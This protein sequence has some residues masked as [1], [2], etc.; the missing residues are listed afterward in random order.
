MINGIRQAIFDL[1]SYV[2]GKPIAELLREIPGLKPNRIVKLASNESPVGPS[3]KAVRAA[4]K[5]IR[6]AHL[7]PEPTAY[8]LRQAIARKHAIAADG[9]IVT[10]GADEA[11]R[12]VAETLLEPQDTVVISRYAFPRFCQHAQLMGSGIIEVPMK[13]FCHDLK[14]MGRAAA[15]RKAKAVFIANPNNPTGTFNSDAEMREL[16]KSFSA[17]R[18]WIILDEAYYEFARDA[19]P[20]DYPDSLPDFFKLYP[21]LIV[22]RTFSKIAG[23]AGLRI[24]YAAAAPQLIALMHRARLVFNVSSPAQAAAIAGLNDR[25]HI[26]KTL[27]CVRQG[28]RF[29]EGALEEFG[30]QA[31]KP[32]AANFIFAGVPERFIRQGGAAKLYQEL[33]QE[34]VIIRPVGE[35]GLENYVRI[36]IGNA[37]QNRALI[38]ALKKV[39][40]TRG[41]EALPPELSPPRKRGSR[42]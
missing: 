42:S 23:L 20:K 1:E 18:P 25:S 14:A 19:F 40:V 41:A 28:R 11:L 38:R 17:D 2:P 36:T 37:G 9:V 13:S 32:S 3:P 33:L 6:Q 16:F 15:E 4:V 8:D 10:S 26:T 22:L 31:V 24:G 27:E 21:K 34:G 29:L 7:Y 39:L 12:L 5:A 30:F 35:K